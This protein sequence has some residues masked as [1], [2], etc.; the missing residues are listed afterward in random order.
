MSFT[1]ASESGLKVEGINWWTPSQD[2][3]KKKDK[4]EICCVNKPEK[5]FVKLQHDGGCLSKIQ[6]CVGCLWNWQYNPVKCHS[7]DQEKIRSPVGDRWGA[8]LI[9]GTDEKEDITKRF[10]DDI[11][12]LKDRVI[13]KATLMGVKDN[14]VTVKKSKTT[15]K[16]QLENAFSKFNTPEISTIV[17]VYSGHHGDGK[18][19]LDTYPLKDSE[20]EKKIICL[21]HVTK[22]IV[23]LDCCHPKKLNLGDKAVLQINAVTSEQKAI[24]GQTG[25]L[26]VNDI[27]HVL[28][29]P[30]E[31]KCCRNTPLIRD[32]DMHR[33]FNN[34][35][36]NAS[37][38]PSQHSYTQGDIDHIVMFRPVDSGWMKALDKSLESSPVQ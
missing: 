24:C 4:C 34:N 27:V 32:Y 31:C 16:E 5:T 23:F 14:V 13:T 17:L 3:G 9:A 6:M 22:V 35:P 10:E 26:F 30:W 15:Y 25:S 29:E 2:D 36:Y 19:Q 8:I 12:K 20:L 18:F 37:T 33:Y 1:D 28:T 7:C 38:E 21:Q 11:E